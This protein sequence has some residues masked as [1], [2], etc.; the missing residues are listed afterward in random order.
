[1]NGRRSDKDKKTE[2]SKCC[3]CGWVGS[4]AEKLLV[5]RSNKIVSDHT[6]PSCGGLDFYSIDEQKKVETI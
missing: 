5:P 3:R 1:M 6:C 4:D 2:L